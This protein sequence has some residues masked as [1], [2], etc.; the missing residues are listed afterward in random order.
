M[1]VPFP[2]TSVFL[3]S[4]WSSHAWPLVCKSTGH[5]WPSLLLFFCP[6]RMET[7][8]YSRLSCDRKPWL[9]FSATDEFNYR[10]KLT[11][12]RP[13]ISACILSGSY[14]APKQ[15]C[16]SARIVFSV[17]FLFMTAALPVDMLTLHF[18]SIRLHL[19][20]HVLV[21]WPRTYLV[22][23]RGLIFHSVR[24]RLN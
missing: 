6:R 19:I 9:A 11:C 12:I 3:R 22:H 15:D 10:Q 20:F 1:A 4:Y 16:Q 21:C 23:R 18:R 24:Q 14:L 17:S 7:G 5:G 2:S 8:G 13:I